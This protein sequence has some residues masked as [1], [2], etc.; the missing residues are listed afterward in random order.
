MIT[1]AEVHD[2]TSVVH[3]NTSADIL[4]MTSESREPKTKRSSTR[5]KNEIARLSEEQHIEGSKRQKISVPPK[6]PKVPIAPLK[7]FKA[8]KEVTVVDVVK[9]SQLKSDKTNESPVFQAMFEASMKKVDNT[10]AAFTTATQHIVQNHSTSSTSADQS[11]VIT[12]I[13]NR[14]DAQL[15]IVNKRLEEQLAAAAEDREALKVEREATSKR[16]DQQLAVVSK[17][18]ADNSRL[19]DVIVDVKTDN[20]KEVKEIQSERIN[21]LKEFLKTMN[22]QSCKRE[23]STNTRNHEFQLEKLKQEVQLKQAQCT[24]SATSSS[25]SSSMAATFD[26]L[27][28]LV[29]DVQLLSEM[30]KK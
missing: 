28:K 16:S 14:T 8:N 21:D 5:S 17:L 3:G 1:S 7:K 10:I 25:S 24:S 15:A 4:D 2:K 11:L 29:K 30:F 19:V 22:D 13:L 12:Q 18:T 9:P 27:P 20:V 6:E 26:F 23:E